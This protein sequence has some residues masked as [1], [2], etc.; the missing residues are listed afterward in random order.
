[1]V[2]LLRKETWSIVIATLVTMLIWIWAARETRDQRQ[3]VVQ[4]E[5]LARNPA[6][7]FIGTD[8]NTVSVTLQGS[9]QA[10]RDFAASSSEPFRFTPGI[11]GVPD[12]VGTHPIDVAAL[13]AR[14]ERFSDLG[15]SIEECEPSSIQLELDR[16]VSVQ[17]EVRPDLPGARLDGDPVVTPS[18]VQLSMRQQTR[19]RFPE[20]I[21][22]I[23]GAEPWRIDQLA[24]GQE[25][26]LDVRVAT[27]ETLIGEPNV[28]IVPNSVSVEFSIK[29]QIRMTTL[30]TVR[31]HLAGPWED[32]DDYKVE[33]DP[34]SLRQVTISGDAELIRRI[35]AESLKV[36]AFVHVSSQQKEQR[37]TS[38]PISFLQAFVPAD[39]GSG[40]VGRPVALEI[41]PNESMPVVNLT[42]TERAQ[43]ADTDT[44]GS[45]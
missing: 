33:I 45:D 1:M 19:T 23:A 36:F 43:P 28:R 24:S 30:D 26:T 31:V 3:V 11:D 18:T 15:L 35:T 9:R 40:M 6:D 25:H 17:A 34:T 5:F 42:I 27:P 29:S 38:A 32:G 20:K 7:W 22:L 39:D 8:A 16:I 2:H 37:I 41:D 12:A 10:L 13:L 44:N 21:T 14:D 4:I